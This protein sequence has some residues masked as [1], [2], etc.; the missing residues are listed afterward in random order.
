MFMGY[1]LLV[2][3]EELRQHTITTTHYPLPTTH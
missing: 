3:V 1:R 2:I